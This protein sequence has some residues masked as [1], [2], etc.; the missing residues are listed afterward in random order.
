MNAS[1]TL[2]NF[3]NEVSP[4][5]RLL[6][7]SARL[8]LTENEIEEIKDLIS[9]I[10][11]WKLFERIAL[12][13]KLASL[14]Y[15]TVVRKYALAIPKATAEFLQRVYIKILAKNIAIMKEFT[16]LKE[17]LNRSEIDYIPLK[18]V[19]LIEELYTDLGLRHISDI[20]LLFRTEDTK[21]V[22][23]VFRKN[24]YK[25]Y[26]VD[27]NRF[28]RKWTQNP[29]PYQYFKNNTSIDFHIGLNRVGN[30]QL[31][32]EDYWNSARKKLAS[33]EHQLEAHFEFVHL[34]FHCFKHLAGGAISLAWL[35]ELPLYI[36]KNN[37]NW[38]QF[39]RRSKQFNCLN[40]NI[41]VIRLLEEIHGEKYLAETDVTCNE[42]TIS[43]SSVKLLNCFK[44]ENKQTVKN[45]LSA[46]LFFET[47]HLS[48]TK[49]IIVVFGR[50]FPSKAFLE[51]RYG[52]I[53]NYVWTMVKR[54]LVYVKR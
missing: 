26:I 14:C 36:E 47:K 44:I 3:W 46:Q 43:N 32:V 41:A 29:S 51:S 34:C 30:F 22:R 15:H 12:Q 18:G 25:E 31:N 19:R 6:L 20:D 38:I 48:L 50:L 10:N 42:Q 40:E 7:K 8:K 21:K 33:H 23:D 49:K 16:D 37:I 11:D 2:Q 27:E 24:G 53:N 45:S 4:E 17:I 39:L 5:A 52:K 1:D 54:Y 28:I 13:T 35:I 9:E